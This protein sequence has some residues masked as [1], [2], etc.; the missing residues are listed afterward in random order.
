VL[1]KATWFYSHDI[2]LDIQMASRAS[3]LSLSDTWT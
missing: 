1:K 3:C 2:F